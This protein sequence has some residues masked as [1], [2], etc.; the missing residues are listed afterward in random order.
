ML[1]TQITDNE[2]LVDIPNSLT[3]EIDYVGSNPDDPA[4]QCQYNLTFHSVYGCPHS[5]PV[6]NKKVCNA[7]G[8]CGYDTLDRD[9]PKCFCYSTI[10]GIACEL[11]PAPHKH[12]VFTPSSLPWPSADTYNASSRAVRTF[13]VNK[14]AYDGTVHSMNVTFDLGEF[15]NIDKIEDADG[16]RYEYYVGTVP[17]SAAAS[18]CANHS[19]AV[20]QV[21]PETKAC[22]VAGGWSV[23]W[24]L[25]DPSNAAKGVTLT[26][27]DGDVCDKDGTPRQ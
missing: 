20:Y 4:T 1:T 2:Q 7:Y 6:Y 21:D 19:G 12:N 16:M 25:Y 17:V 22:V 9:E 27:G 24:T 8:L 15:A 14:T 10:G 18:G 13:R 5:C 26:F 3:S 23:D 11:D